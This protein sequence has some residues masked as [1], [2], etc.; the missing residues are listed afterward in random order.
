MTYREPYF[1]LS[2]FDYGVSYPSSGVRFPLNASIHVMSTNLSAPYHL[3]N[4]RLSVALSTLGGH[5]NEHWDLNHMH[6]WDFDIAICYISIGAIK[7]IGHGSI[8]QGLSTS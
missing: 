6:E 7:I 2:T 4:N 5:F 3:T 1:N 8:V